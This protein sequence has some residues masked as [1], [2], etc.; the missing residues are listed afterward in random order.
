V[1]K[2]VF[3]IHDHFRGYQLPPVEQISVPKIDL[4]KI[5]IQNYQKR[6]ETK[7]S[8]ERYT[9]LLPEEMKLKV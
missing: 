4:A 2:Y 3:E 7:S 5:A 6:L 9:L 8:R 1:L